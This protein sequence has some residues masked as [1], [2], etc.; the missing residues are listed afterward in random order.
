MKKR[1]EVTTF[2][3][4]GILIVTAV[5]TFFF[6][7][8]TVFFR[9]LV[10]E[11]QKTI[12]VP[13]QAKIVKAYVESC[14]KD[15]A[16]RGITLLSAQ[17]GYVVIPDDP[18]PR[19]PVNMFSNY[20]DIFNDGTSAVPYW[21]YQAANGVDKV[22]MPA[23][24]AVRDQLEVFIN[25]NLAGC[26]Q[27]F[28]VLRGRGYEIDQGAPRSR[29]A[30]NDENVR[31][32]VSYPLDVQLR[33]FQFHFD[34]FSATTERALGKMYKAARDVLAAEN[35]KFFIEDYALDSMAVYDQIP[36]SG[37]DFECSPR[38]WQ[39]S[40]VIED[41]KNVFAATIPSIKIK[42]SQYALADDF[43]KYFVTDVGTRPGDITFQFT[44]SP[45]WPF[46]IDILGE[47]SEVLRGKP[48]A[49]PTVA[50]FVN[51]F[52]C[53]NTYHFVYNLKFPVVISLY[54]EESGD[55]FQFATQ[56]IIDHNQPRQNSV[57]VPTIDAATEICDKRATPLKV[58]AMGYRSDGS[59]AAL[60]DAKVSLKCLNEVCDM[61][62]T[63][64]D[65]S[66]YSL[67]GQ[68]PACFN[69]RL[70]AE[71]EGHVAASE[72]LSTNEEATITL[73]L[74]R[75]YDLDASAMT[76]SDTGVNPVQPTEQ[77]TFTFDN[78]D[79]DYMTT[80]VYP[81]SNTV[82]L[83]PG[84]YEITTST[85]VQSSGFTIPGKEVKSCVDAPRGG[86]LGIFGLNEKK[87]V[88]YRTDDVQLD[89]V[90]A[91]GG[92]VMWSVSR[93]QL[94]GAK[95]LTLYAVRGPLPRTLEELSKT[96]SDI[97]ENKYKIRLPE[98]A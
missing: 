56:A 12:T 92:T 74:E 83:A 75:L 41:M 93:E 94:A 2:V 70:T 79:V 35:E 58:Y 85:V 57:E 21:Y 72:I 95:K 26:L 34:T 31:V 66:E 5:V 36:F 88:N 13:E 61:G 77:V 14:V 86:V 7:R 33:D 8:N 67:S 82:Q 78:K 10:Q 62:N 50:R 49:E 89:Q 40:K 9:D 53:A 80:L 71:K 73:T 38:T 24:T 55:T 68:F 30:I 64:W 45:T 98:L 16:D 91:G 97:A 44:Y 37:V 4:I 23:L 22:Q 32:D 19:G 51:Q 1:G 90:V 59:L 47:N 54:D 20:V 60:D 43:A 42:G 6:V 81:G 76:V 46:A 69:A 48:F 17:G 28:T 52:F 96:S 87:C 84:T 25:D 18:L 65:G 11:T 39:R 15:V 27:D 29:V 63:L 3:I